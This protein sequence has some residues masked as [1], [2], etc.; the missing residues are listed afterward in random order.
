MTFANERVPVWVKA[1]KEQY[2]KPETKYASV[3][4]V[5]FHLCLFGLMTDHITG[6]ALEPPTSV[7]SWQRLEA[8][9]LVPLHIL[10]S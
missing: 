6:T 7:T 1:V 4:L 3:G 8:L 9:P 2:G 10:P 5:T